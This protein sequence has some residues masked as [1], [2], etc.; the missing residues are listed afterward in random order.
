LIPIHGEMEEGYQRNNHWRGVPIIC[1]RSCFKKGI[2]FKL[3]KSRSRRPIRGH[4]LALLLLSYVGEDERAYLDEIVEP[5]ELELFLP[6][7]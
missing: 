4:L 3:T 1:V 7:F 2:V 5:L 6:D